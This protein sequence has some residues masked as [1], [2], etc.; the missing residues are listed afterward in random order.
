M[1]NFVEDGHQIV[2]MTDKSISMYTDEQIKTIVNSKNYQGYPLQF[3]R[4]SKLNNDLLK[5]LHKE[6]KLQKKIMV[7]NWEIFVFDI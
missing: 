6:G 5:V 7:N 4:L 1:D 3:L 2:V